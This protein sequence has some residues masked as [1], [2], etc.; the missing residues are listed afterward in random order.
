MQRAAA[1]PLRSV[2]GVAA[3][4]WSSGVRKGLQFA[5]LACSS[6][7]QHWVQRDQPTSIHSNGPRYVNLRSLHSIMDDTILAHDVFPGIS[8]NPSVPTDYNGRRVRNTLTFLTE[9][10]AIRFRKVMELFPS[11]QI[12]SQ[13][14]STIP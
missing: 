8:S 7:V 10:C 13:A 2:R 9:A 4:C 3:T 1:S 12:I 5:I 6:L 11:V 14:F